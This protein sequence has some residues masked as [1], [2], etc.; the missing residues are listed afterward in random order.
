MNEQFLLKGLKI[1]VTSQEPFIHTIHKSLAEILISNLL[2]NALRYSDAGTEIHISI[3]KNSF[4]IS[5]PGQPL[6]FV[7]EKLFQRFFK[8]AS[9]SGSLGIGLSLVKTIADVHQL[10]VS[11]F[12]KNSHH[13]FELVA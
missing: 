11:Y 3:T 6:S 4:T 5:N 12:Y 7:P 8:K 10:K 2:I 9:A 13:I 1:N